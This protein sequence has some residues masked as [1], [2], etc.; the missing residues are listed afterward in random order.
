MNALLMLLIS[1]SHERLCDM[2][3]QPHLCTYKRM[4]NS[5]RKGT[6]CIVSYRY[7]YKIH[8]RRM[9]FKH[10]LLFNVD[11]WSFTKN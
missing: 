6:K 5:V 3:V 2:R 1:T 7:S 10:S 8:T 9:F 4:N 11:I